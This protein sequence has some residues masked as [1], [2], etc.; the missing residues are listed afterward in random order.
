MENLTF[1]KN[2]SVK[3][4]VLFS[5]ALFRAKKY[6]KNISVKNAVPFSI[7]KIRCG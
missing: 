4:A 2:I 7:R 1:V 6:V 5:K 3:N